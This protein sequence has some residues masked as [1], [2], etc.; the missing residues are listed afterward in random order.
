M[1]LG[2]ADAGND[3][4][5]DDPEAYDLMAQAYGPGTNGPLWVVLEN[6]GGT[7]CATSPAAS[8]PRSGHRESPR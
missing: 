8:R 1:R 5:Y 6:K 7:L 2:F 3:P 4:T